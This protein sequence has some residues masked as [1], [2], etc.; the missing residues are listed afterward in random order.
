MQTLLLNLD[1][2]PERLARFM[3]RNAFLTSVERQPAVD[4]RVADRAPLIETRVIDSGLEC[5]PGAL[6]CALSHLL[7]WQR[8]VTNSIV[9]TVL[10][11]DAVVNRVF[12]SEAQRVLSELPPDWDI[13][14]WGWNFNAP[15]FLDLLPGVSAGALNCDQSSMA[16]RLTHFQALEVR[17]RPVRML[18]ACGTVAY[19]VSTRGAGKLIA[20]CVPLRPI[21]GVRDPHTQGPFYGIDLAMSVLFP[22]MNAY[23]CVPPL[24][25]TPNDGSTTGAA[26]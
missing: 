17:S 14:Y 11:D 3:A 10:E 21:P 20:G 22:S 19:T 18:G 5:T 15:L 8:A 16:Q 12:E 24:I 4:G 2:Q 13:V 9:T 6:G 26:A 23:A 25:V 7:V 1:R